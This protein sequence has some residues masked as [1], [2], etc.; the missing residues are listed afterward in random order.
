MNKYKSKLPR[1]DLKRFA[2]EVISILSFH[3]KTLAKLF[4]QIADKLANSDFKSGRVEDPTK[5]DEK[6]EKKVKRYCKEF[7]D[8]AAHKHRKL[9]KEKTA[10]KP[11]P[12]VFK[13]NGGTVAEMTNSPVLNLDASPDIKREGNSDD[14][15]VKM[16]ED[17]DEIP[18]SPTPSAGL[19]D[20]GLKRKR[21][22]GD[23]E[24]IKADIDL[25]KSPMKR[26]KSESP[27]PPTPPPARTVGIPVIQPGHSSPAETNGD[28]S[29]RKREA[30]DNEDR[31][32]PADISR[33]PAKR[34]RSES[35]PTSLVITN[36]NSHK[37]GRDED[38][39]EDNRVNRDASKSPAKRLKSESPLPP[40]PPPGPPVDTPPM[41]SEDASPSETMDQLHADT[42][43]ADKSMADVLAEAQQDP[44]DG[45]DIGD[46][47]MQDANDR[48]A[49]SLARERAR[50]GID[51]EGNLS[52]G[53][54]PPGSLPHSPIH[55]DKH[56]VKSPRPW[57]NEVTIESPPRTTDKHS[58]RS[59]GIKANL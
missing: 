35:P 31:K 33:S 32:V 47:S 7:F 53:P 38:E 2:K 49:G 52:T 25:S 43:F 39:E 42:S 59:D 3:Q 17:E 15:D 48:W 13:P 24:E 37:R 58:P 23:E 5:I 57:P 26:M 46:L 40:P 27:C 28:V 34:T 9:E 55:Y 10:R 8:K 18:T 6:H 21:E 19:N 51:D 56:G 12:E 44:G 41:Q 54:S 16:S 36:G 50:L 30:D 45:D 4:G 22:G 1:D 20:I 11:R 14:D 29:K